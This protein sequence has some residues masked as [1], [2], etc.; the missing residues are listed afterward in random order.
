MN[1]YRQ[2]VS[3][4]TLHEHFAGLFEPKWLPN[5]Q[6][7]VCFRLRISSCSP[8][9][10]CVW[11]SELNSWVNVSFN[12]IFA[13]LQTRDTQPPWLAA[14]Y[15]PVID[16]SQSGEVFLLFYRMFIV[17]MRSVM[18]RLLSMWIFFFIM[19]RSDRYQQDNSPTG[20]IWGVGS[21]QKWSVSIGQDNL[22]CHLT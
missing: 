11:N 5:G 16:S 3:S 13:Y 1:I 10:M 4:S 2:T 12:G 21:P 9:C 22:S 14:R 17:L 15:I 6:R 8:S 19:P 18:I 20:K 7:F